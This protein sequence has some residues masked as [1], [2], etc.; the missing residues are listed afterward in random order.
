[1]DVVDEDELLVLLSRL[2]KLLFDTTHKIKKSLTILLP[3][4]IQLLQILQE[5][6]SPN[7]M[8]KSF[9]GNHS[10]EAILGAVHGICA[11][12]IE[13]VQNCLQLQR[14][15]SKNT[16]DGLY[17]SDDNYNEVVE[18]CRPIKIHHASFTIHV[19]PGGSNLHV[20]QPTLDQNLEQQCM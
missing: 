5:S 16:I 8:S 20:V 3:N 13:F 15:I 11:P 1:M 10:L 2:E 12:Q 7:T 18:Y 6:N 14:W 19:R 9:N 17:H 4:L